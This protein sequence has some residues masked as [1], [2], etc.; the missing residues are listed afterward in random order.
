ME[1]WQSFGWNLVSVATVRKRDMDAHGCTFVSMCGSTGA[2][3]NGKDPIYGHAVHVVGLILLL[4]MHV[5]NRT[6]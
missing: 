5:F 1:N 4:L 6:S 2:L 3:R